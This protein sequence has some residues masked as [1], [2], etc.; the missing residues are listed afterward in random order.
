MALSEIPPHAQEPTSS[1]PAPATYA[2]AGVS[3]EA[4]NEMVRLIKP[5]AQR[6]FTPGVM[7]GIGGFGALFKEDFSQYQEPIL[8]SSTDGVGTKL[9]LAFTL[10]RHDTVGQDLV[11]MC[12]NDLVCSGAKPLF[13]LDYFATGK[14]EPHVGEQVVKGIADGCVE[15]ACALIGG[16]TAELPGFYSAGEYDL[17]GFSVGVV[18]KAEII[19]GSNVQVSDVIIGIPSSGLHSNGY[20]LARKVLEP[21]GLESDIPELESTLGEAMLRPTR[22]YVKAM[23]EMMANVPVKAMAHI[24]G[25]GFYENI[26]RVLP[27]STLAAIERNS[28]PIPPIF[29]LIQERA[30]VA[31]RE[32]FT[33]FNMG[34]GLA[35]VVD[36]AD[37][38][39]ALSSQEKYF[40]AYQ[41]G[42]IEAGEGEAR[43]EL[44]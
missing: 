9:K 39:A 26:P 36:K 1:T 5:H 19:D 13:F 7:G 23:Q 27:Q 20:S 40:G 4:G 21:L 43:V 6:T 11:A 14:L 18:D 24:T 34:I 8:V 29:S 12:V 28:W 10:N 17:A 2:Q 3:I 30:G 15:A 25:G 16:E 35:V 41:L 44:R 33:T 22:I 38:E 31:E 32:M 42:I 37:V